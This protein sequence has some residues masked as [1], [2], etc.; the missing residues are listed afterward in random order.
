MRSARSRNYRNVGMRP[1]SALRRYGRVVCLSLMQ[2][3]RLA[4]VVINHVVGRSEASQHHDL[5]SSIIIAMIQNLATPFPDSWHSI[6]DVQ[7]LTLCDMDIVRGQD[8]I[9]TYGSPSPPEP[10]AR[11]ALATVIRSFD[12]TFKEE[13]MAEYA[14]R[15]EAEWTG[16]RADARPPPRGL[17]ERAKYEA[18]TDE[19][20][21]PF[22]AVYLHGGWSVLSDPARFRNL[23]TRLSQTGGCR[24]Y[25]VRYRLAPQSPFPAALLDSLVSYLT[26][27]YPPPDAF[28]EPVPASHI[29]F[30]GD[31][32]GANL[33]F[34]L[35]QTILELRRLGC[36]QIR[37]H[38]QVRD[39]PLPAGLVCF[40]PFI[41][42]TLSSSLFRA[43][44]RSTLDYLP[45]RDELIRHRWAPCAA[46]PASPPRN[47]LYTVDDLLSHQL[48]SPITATSWHGSPPVYMSVGDELLLD[49]V[50]FF[51]ARLVAQDVPVV[52][53]H[54]QAMPHDH[55][56]FLSH[57]PAADRCLDVC[58][59]FIR[60]V[61]DPAAVVKPSATYIHSKTLREEPLQ[62]DRLSLES[63]DQ[64]CRRVKDSIAENICLWPVREQ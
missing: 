25:S 59:A 42:F 55:A 56:L 50:R 40:S 53:E 8:W 37:W 49:D 62:F 52:M 11:H 48:V 43:P 19:C 9:A 24:I 57:I 34:A 61:V 29:V 1:P 35:V 46:W 18:L 6:S 54:Y 23:L 63:Y 26:L 44:V 41:D 21:E 31:S 64:V 45:M 38:G 4:G 20:S 15:V 17:S 47:Q 12:A 13:N 14:P 30:S 16:Y 39:L 7:R 32:F 10:D 58:G 36:S 3:P 22:T 60:T 33:C 2:A 5:L 27:L 28:H 51:A